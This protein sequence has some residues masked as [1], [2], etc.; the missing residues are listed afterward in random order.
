MTYGS[1][2]LKVEVQQ[3]EWQN[4]TFEPELKAENQ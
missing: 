4:R 3:W 2:K 1:G